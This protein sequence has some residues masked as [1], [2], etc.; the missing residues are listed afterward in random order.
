V[1][2]FS[3]ASSDIDF[4][5]RQLDTSWPTLRSIARRLELLAHDIGAVFL[6]YPRANVRDVEL[7]FSKKGISHPVLDNAEFHRTRFLYAALHVALYTAGLE[8]SVAT[9]SEWQAFVRLGV[10]KGLPRRGPLLLIRPSADVYAVLEG[11]A[12]GLG[13]DIEV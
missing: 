5:I 9:S 6:N 8:P 3:I 7:I 2:K 10:K 13:K 1:E 12:Q 4:V 11:Q